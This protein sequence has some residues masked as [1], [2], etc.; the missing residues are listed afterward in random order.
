MYIFQFSS[1]FFNIISHEFEWF[2]AFDGVVWLIVK[3]DG[4]HVA[5]R[6]RRL[7]LFPGDS[8][9]FLLAKDDGSRSFLESESPGFIVLRTRRLF[10]FIQEATHFSGAADCCNGLLLEL[11]NGIKLVVLW[12]R[13]CFHPNFSIFLGEMI[14]RSIPWPR[15]LVVRGTGTDLAFRTVF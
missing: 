11:G 3:F 13:G 15:G 7:V 14:L 8:L 9:P 12:S 5:S 6:A 2:M 4:D 10:A 1:S